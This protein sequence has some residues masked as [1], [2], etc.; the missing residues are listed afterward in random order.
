MTYEDKQALWLLFWV[1]VLWLLRK[2]PPFDVIWE[3]FKMFIIITL[4]F[5]TAGMI[6]KAIKN[7]FK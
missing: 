6:A 5:V 7:W 4:L 2:I 3:V 1:F